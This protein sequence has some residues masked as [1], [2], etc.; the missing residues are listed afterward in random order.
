MK[1]NWLTKTV[2]E[3]TSY[4]AKGIPPKYEEK[5]SDSTV[6]VLNQK[7]N[8]DYRIS[9]KP[10]RLH[11]TARKRVSNEKMLK[12][13]DVLINS[14]GVGTAGRVAQIIEIPEPTTVDGHMIIMRSTSE[15]DSLYYGYAL[16]L[17]QSKIESFAEGSTGQT[18][19]NKNRLVDEISI[20]YPDDIK[21]QQYIASIL[22][23][24]DQK[25]E[26]NNKI[27]DNLAA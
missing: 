6:R 27:N 7:C 8:R 11:D 14:T 19:I 5:V 10:S 21:V 2:G 22:Y 17:Y 25:I 13:G 18:E 9:Y 15:I 20:T 26:L 3:L 23:S 1:F 24:F 12:A 16:K 4:M